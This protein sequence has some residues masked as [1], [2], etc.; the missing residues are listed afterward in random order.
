MS[1]EQATADHAIDG[2]TD[3]YSLGAVLYEMLT[4]DPPYTGSTS[5]TVIAKMLTD[6]PRSMRLSRPSVPIKV[7]EAVDHALAKLPAD[8]FASGLEFA[9]ALQPPYP[10]AG[11]SAD[12]PGAALG[13]CLKF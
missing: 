1:P 8:R 6:R 9:E 7:E 4:G 10:S 5:Q 13:L 2:R 3:V 12:V 11:T